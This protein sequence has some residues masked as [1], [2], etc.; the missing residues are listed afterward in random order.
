MAVL[1]DDELQY[2]SISWTSEGDITFGK[3][4]ESESLLECDNALMTDVSYIGIKTGPGII[5]TWELIGSMEPKH[6]LYCSSA[7]S[8]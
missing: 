4:S 3:Q 1:S 6:K 7:C 5:G 8:S 2:F